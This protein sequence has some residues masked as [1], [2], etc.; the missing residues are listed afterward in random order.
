MP[1][2]RTVMRHVARF[3]AVVVS[4]GATLSNRLDLGYAL[5]R[6]PVMIGTQG[7]ELVIIRPRLQ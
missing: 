3:V 2:R 5:D 6:R 1:P 4:H 7:L